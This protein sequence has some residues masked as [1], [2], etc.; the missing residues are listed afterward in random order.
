MNFAIQYANF[1]LRRQSKFTAAEN[2][3]YTYALFAALYN[4]AQIE[5]NQALGLVREINS[6]TLATAAT[7][8]FYT[9]PETMLGWEIPEDGVS[10]ILS[11]T[12]LPDPLLRID[13]SDA[14][15]LF[16]N[17][18][19][20]LALNS[21]AYWWFKEDDGTKIG[22]GYPPMRAGTLRIAHVKE[23]RAVDSASAIYAGT[24][25]TLT[26]SLT[27][28]DGT[29]T[30]SGS[31]PAG[32]LPLDDSNLPLF[33]FAVGALATPP[34]KWYRVA[35]VTL[36]GSNNITAMELAT[37]YTGATASGLAFVAAQVSDIER[38]A[39]S[40][41]TALLPCYYALREVSAGSDS[42]QAEAWGAK[43][44]EELHISAPS[45]KGTTM[46]S[47]VQLSRISPGRP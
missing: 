35:S 37:N 26:A 33:E 31:I 32:R 39:K 24:T 14:R 43:F 6:Q 21:C 27:N 42:K 1:V 15:R 4:Q 41:R 3:N 45:L 22:I 7:D 13:A 8:F 23:P 47:G 18:T 19:N 44:D 20:A 28:G 34:S 40:T 25:D 17:F 11:S 10:L 38:Y 2:A 29:V 5:I 46:P 9:R 30:L 16:K 12:E 36:D